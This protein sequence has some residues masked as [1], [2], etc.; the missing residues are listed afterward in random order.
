MP[1]TPSPIADRV[2][3]L[4]G[5]TLFTG[6]R[7]GGVT[8]I[9]STGSTNADMAAFVRAGGTSFCL[10]VADHQ[11]GGRGRFTRSW[12]DVPG[13]S[14]AISALVPN[15]RPSQDWGWLSM[16]AGLAVAKVIEEVGGADRSRVTLKWPN[17]VLVDLD[18]DQGGKV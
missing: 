15:D 9:D 16:V 5:D 3:E 12:Q 18:T 1:S 8:C 7:G 17:D 14:L 6:P 10:L 11:E 4:A 13:T 2:L